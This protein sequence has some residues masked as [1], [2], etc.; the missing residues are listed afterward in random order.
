[1]PF[2]LND[3]E[4]TLPIFSTVCN[5]CRHWIRKPGRKCE[6]FPEGIPLPIWLGENDHHLPYDGDQGIRFAPVYVPHGRMRTRKPQKSALTL[7]VKQLEA[8]VR[9]LQ[10]RLNETRSLDKQSVVIVTEEVTPIKASV[11]K[12]KP[13]IRH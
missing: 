2:S 4:A 7:R 9:Q 11:R 10:Q 12:A 13:Y 3:F 5:G 8:H 1:M 6:A